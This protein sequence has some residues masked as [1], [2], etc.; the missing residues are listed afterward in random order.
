MEL[1][2]WGGFYAGADG[3]YVVEGQKNEAETDSAEVIRVIRYDKSWQR[4]GAARITGNTALFGGQV[5]T[6][7]RTGCVEMTERNGY[8]YIA[9][10]H[11]GYVDPQYNQGHQGLLLIEVNEQT[12]QGQIVDCDLWHS[13]SQYIKAD[14]GKLYLLEQSE[15]SYCTSLKSYSTVLSNPDATLAVLKYGGPASV[16]DATVKYILSMQ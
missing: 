4:V 10:G 2:I 1:S 5:R 14:G 8:L 6:P 7:F 3:Y 12:M 13:F 9:T 11:E 16:S 15:G